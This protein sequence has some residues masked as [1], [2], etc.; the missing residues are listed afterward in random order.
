[1][2][3]LYMGSTAAGAQALKAGSSKKC[4]R[5]KSKVVNRL[6]P[7]VAG[8]FAL[9]GAAEL[10]RYV[11]PSELDDMLTDI[12]HRRGNVQADKGTPGASL[13]LMSWIGQL[14]QML[15]DSSKSCLPTT[16]CFFWTRKEPGSYEPFLHTI[17]YSPG[18]LRL[19]RATG[20]MFFVLLIGGGSGGLAMVR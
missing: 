9:M 18:E 20:A 16:M 15:K 7:Y 11:R 1:M 19:R 17:R 13:S 4:H 10:A 2:A 3:D 5:Q 6:R 8:M 14:G 12:E